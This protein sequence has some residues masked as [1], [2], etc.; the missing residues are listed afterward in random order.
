[1]TINT[2]QQILEKE[3]AIV[4]TCTFYFDIDFKYFNESAIYPVKEFQEI[5]LNEN[6]RVTPRIMGELYTFRNL[7]KKRA[8]SIRRAAK[9]I[10]ERKDLVMDGYRIAKQVSKLLYRGI[11]QLERR[12]FDFEN[13]VP[14]Q[15]LRDIIFL[16]ENKLKIK[17]QKD[18]PDSRTDEEIVATALY[19]SVF[20]NPISIV[21]ADDDLYRLVMRCFS[22]LASPALSP[23]NRNILEGFIHQPV[24]LYLVVPPREKSLFRLSIDTARLQEAYPDLEFLKDD[25]CLFYIRHC[26]ANLDKKFPYLQ[27]MLK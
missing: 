18:K 14:Y 20:Q 1:M 3:K 9:K 19:L 8:S 7:V 17:K 2:L 12:I 4:D 11:S 22:I 26:L 15:N 16:L 10:K 25:N 23:E 21:S 6:M 24:R 13:A 5:A 27:R